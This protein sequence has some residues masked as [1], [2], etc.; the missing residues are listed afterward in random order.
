MCG[1]FYLNNKF[2]TA[3]IIGIVNI[4][5]RV[6]SSTQFA[7]SSVS[8]SYISARLSITA[9]QGVPP[10]INIAALKIGSSGRK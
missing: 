3:L 8:P 7:A 6:L 2:D 5:S 10:N 4:H 1:V 9:A